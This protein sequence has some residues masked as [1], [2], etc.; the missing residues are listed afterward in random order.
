MIYMYKNV[1]FL[2]HTAQRISNNELSSL[3][4]RNFNFNHN[5]GE[6]LSKLFL[7]AHVYVAPISNTWQHRLPISNTWQFRY[8]LMLELGNKV[9]VCPPAT[10]FLCNGQAYTKTL[11]TE[12]VTT[13]RVDIY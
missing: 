11:Q 8:I 12:S 2:Q 6:E 9:E 1:Y 3:V 5:K 10:L 13:V 7:C 4:P